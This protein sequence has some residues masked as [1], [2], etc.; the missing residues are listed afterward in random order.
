MLTLSPFGEVMLTLWAF[1][2]RTSG[3]CSALEARISSLAWRRVP[4]LG[5]SL[6]LRGLATSHR[7]PRLPAK[8]EF[9]SISSCATSFAE[10]QAPVYE[11]VF[12]DPAGKD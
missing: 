5:T 7:G 12:N 3:K 11:A 10:P 8:L 4:L 6:H 2:L 1:I 9:S